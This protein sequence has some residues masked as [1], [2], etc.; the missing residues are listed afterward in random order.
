VNVLSSSSSI[1]ITAPWKTKK[2]EEAVRRHHPPSLAHYQKHTEAWENE[3]K[4]R[5]CLGGG[6]DAGTG[7]EQTDIGDQLHRRKENL[8]RTV[9]GMAPSNSISQ[10]CL[11]VKTNL[12]GKKKAYAYLFM[13]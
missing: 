7:I 13:K 12:G 6:R 3:G 5:A 9:C 10:T 4:R 8:C 2:D 1:P 11:L